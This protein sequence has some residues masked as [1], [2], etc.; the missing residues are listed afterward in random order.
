VIFAEEVGKGDW[1][2]FGATTR[3]CRPRARGSAA[4]GL[5]L[6]IGQSPDLAFLAGDGIVARQRGFNQSPAIVTW[7]TLPRHPP[8]L[9]DHC[10]WAEPFVCPVGMRY[11]RAL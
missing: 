5:G 6:S 3:I 10:P 2:R 8:V 1:D 11:R 4:G 9:A 7:A